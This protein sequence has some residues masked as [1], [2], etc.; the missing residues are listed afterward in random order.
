MPALGRHG[1]VSGR[2]RE[3]EHGQAGQLV[4]R[5]G[6]HRSDR[7]S[8]HALF[9]EAS[10][11]LR[12]RAEGA[13][14]LARRPR[15]VTARGGLRRQGA[16]R[17]SQP[18]RPSD[19]FASLDGPQPRQ[20]LAAP[21]PSP[22]LPPP[23]TADLPLRPFAQ[24]Y[25]PLWG[26][27]GKEAYWDACDAGAV[28]EGV[29]RTTLIV[30]SEDD[31]I[32]P[33]GSLPL[34]KITANPHLLCAVTRHGGHMGYTAGLSPLKETWTDRLLVHFLKHLVGR[35][36]GRVAAGGAG[37]ATGCDVARAQAAAGPADF[38]VFAGTQSRL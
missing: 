18:S 27:D 26:L 10:H 7:G 28:L 30:H 9:L 38:S 6:V 4:G 3:G 1:R 34:K 16:S 14:L 21:L 17:R 24:L 5:Y 31:P 29:R 20:P 19:G 12:T 22:S 25:G 2:R 11:G 15:L 13:R 35:P 36:E 33:V 23:A 32:C 8:A 37:G